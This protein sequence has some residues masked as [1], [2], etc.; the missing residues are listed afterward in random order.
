MRYVVFLLLVVN[1]SVISAQ[2]QNRTL[3][4]G[5][6]ERTF[7]VHVPTGYDASVS[8]P[9]VFNFHGLTG[10][11]SQQMSMSGMNTI[12][13]RENF[14]VVYPD[15]LNN[16][17][18][19]T[20]TRDV[21]FTM[22]MLDYIESQ[23]NVD[24][25]RV[26]SMGF[27]M[28]GF[29]SYNLAC[30]ASARIAAITSVTG[31]MGV[32]SCNPGRSVPILQIHGTTDAVV[33]YSVTERILNFWPDNNRCQTG[34]VEERLHSDIVRTLY[35]DCD[36]SA[37]VVLLTMEGIGHIWPRT[38]TGGFG[39]GSSISA[40]EE[41][42]SFFSNFSHPDFADNVTSVKRE[43]DF[44]ISTGPNP[45]KETLLVAVSN[46]KLEKGSSLSVAIYA[47]SG[48]NVL[49]KEFTVDEADFFSKDVC[50]KNLDSGVYL[51]VVK[52][53]NS[54]VQKGFFTKVE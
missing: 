35:T 51:I 13:N 20:G 53:E 36:D 43:G 14:I 37:D 2:T 41:A 16:T 26:Y 33:N 49:T 46:L 32:V 21:D 42:W 7:I 44:A 17:W 28:G 45:I 19:I 15:G 52:A 24:R 31:A 27:S 30:R 10:T 9:V 38:G 54:G 48:R 22:A 8:T 25:A 39:G 5:G 50:V 23:Y 18:D 11:G 29:M 40:S 12:A 1:F 47:L 4:V 3:T 6:V 34:P